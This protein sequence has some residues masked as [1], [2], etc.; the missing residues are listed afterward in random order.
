MDVAMGG[1]VAEELI[2]GK[3]NVTSGA[4][5]DIQQATRIA[6]NMVT[7]FG[8]SEQVGIVFHGGN[9]GEESASSETRAR[10]DA[11]VQRLTHEAYVR[12]KDLLMRYSK[13]HTLLAETLLEY[14][15]LTG[16]EVRDLVRNGRKPQ[17]PALLKVPSTNSKSKGGG[18]SK[19]NE[20]GG[21]GGTGIRGRLFGSSSSS[22]S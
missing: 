7:K 4:S 18:G 6:R 14:E 8:F 20:G 11:E 5:S 1:R 19:S 12:A 16:D 2:F 22:S 15:T 13:E 10:I 9:S 17:R 3:E 21:G